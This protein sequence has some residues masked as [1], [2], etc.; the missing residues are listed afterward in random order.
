MDTCN[1][2]VWEGY[3]EF[4]TP[5]PGLSP[6]VGGGQAANVVITGDSSGIVFQ[7]VDIISGAGAFFPGFF[8]FLFCFVDYLPSSS[9]RTEQKM[10][11]RVEEVVHHFCSE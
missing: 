3:E 10:N 6:P 4:E 11:K 5:S 8:F 7:N 2:V 9:P 1:N